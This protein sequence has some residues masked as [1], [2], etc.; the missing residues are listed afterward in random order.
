VDLN[1][2]LMKKPA[3]KPKFQGDDE[4]KQRFRI[5]LREGIEVAARNG[6]DMEIENIKLEVTHMW[7]SLECKF[8]GGILYLDADK[9]WHK[10]KIFGMATIMT[11]EK[12]N[13]R[14]CYKVGNC[15]HT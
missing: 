11:C 10:D 1:K 7:A 4:I 2:D 5:L 8:C 9:K 14:Q 12:G 13:D 3:E 15:T 6:H